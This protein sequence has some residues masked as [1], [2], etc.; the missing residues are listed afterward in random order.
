MKQFGMFHKKIEISMYM[1]MYIVYVFS[2]YLCEKY[3]M[4]IHVITQHW[5]QKPSEFALNPASDPASPV[6]PESK[7]KRKKKENKLKFFYFFK[8]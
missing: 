3:R 5:V 6:D 7:K 8:K 2:M 1:Y 4:C